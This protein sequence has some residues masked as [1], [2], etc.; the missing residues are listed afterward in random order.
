M[1]I[2][3]IQIASV[4]Y[5]FVVNS[6]ITQLNILK[7]KTIKNE[8]KKNFEIEK[9]AFSCILKENRYIC[10]RSNLEI[11]IFFSFPNSDFLDDN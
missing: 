10:S 3:F 11:C 7:K 4:H 8:Q 6:L 5:V 2:Y 1:I 9:I